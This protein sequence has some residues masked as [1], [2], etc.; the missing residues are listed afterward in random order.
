M[1]DSPG[2]HIYPSPRAN[3]RASGQPSYP[4]SISDQ[5]EEPAAKKPKIEGRDVMEVAS[6][7]V[8]TVTDPRAMLGPEVG[9]R[10]DRIEID[11]QPYVLYYTGT[12][13]LTSSAMPWPLCTRSHAAIVI[14]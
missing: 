10:N 13:K 6:E 3:V 14:C 11:R 2:S 5:S 7:I 8:A 9:K 1:N 12:G 4:R